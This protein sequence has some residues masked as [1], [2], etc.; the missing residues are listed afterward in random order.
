MLWP[1][2][3][4]ELVNIDLSDFRREQQ[5]AVSVARCLEE[6][7]VR[8]SISAKKQRH[9]LSFFSRSHDNESGITGDNNVNQPMINTKQQK[10]KIY[11]TSLEY[12]TTT[13]ELDFSHVSSM[14]SV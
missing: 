12:S 8:R 1:A 11:L 3:L 13:E 10:K 2:G 4:N 7:K 6:F 5:E 14:L 9:M